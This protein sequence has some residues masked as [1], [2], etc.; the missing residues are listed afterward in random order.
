MSNEN[1]SR[2]PTSHQRLIRRKS[3]SAMIASITGQDGDE[4]FR[5]VP[6]MIPARSAITRFPPAAA[7]EA[8]ERLRRGA[9][10]SAAVLTI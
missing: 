10:Q 3:M 6:N 2:K 9:L 5:L 7:N 8:P 4:F 1:C